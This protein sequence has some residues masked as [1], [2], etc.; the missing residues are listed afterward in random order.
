MTP[1]VAPSARDPR[2]LVAF[3]LMTLI[4]GSTWYA[5]RMQLNGTP[6]FVSVAMRFL[7]AAAVVALWMRLAGYSFRVERRLWAWI[8]VHGASMYGINYLFAYGAT[9]YVVSGV[10]ALA[11]ALNIVFSL[12]AEPWLLG[13]RSPRSAWLGAALGLFGL[14]IVLGPGLVVTQSHAIEGRATLIGVGMALAGALIVGVGAVFTARIMR[15]G[16]ATHSLILYGFLTGALIAAIAAAVGGQGWQV[17]W[18]V[19]YLVSLLYLS[20]FGSVLAFAMYLYVVR[21][22]GPVTAGYSSIISPLIALCLSMLLEG[23]RVDLVFAAGVAL[24]LL[25]NAVILRGRAPSMAAR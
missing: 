5:I 24:V 10:V 11:F 16:A 4:W 17:Q 15:Q 7:L 6:L 3:V 12:G 22:L 21:A 8:P 1:S 25:G 20:L 23:F 14:A 18:S 2:A 9:A 19:P 13:R